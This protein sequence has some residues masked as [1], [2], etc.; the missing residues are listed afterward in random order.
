MAIM[1]VANQAFH[2]AGVEI[3]NAQAVTKMAETLGAIVGPKNSVLTNV[4]LVFVLVLF[5]V[6]G[7]PEAGLF[8]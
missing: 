8:R 7:A 5:A 2:V 3:T 4:V 1:I 6:V